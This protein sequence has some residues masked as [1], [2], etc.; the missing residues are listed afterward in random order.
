MIVTSVAKPLS[1][2]DQYS[3]GHLDVDLAE[4]VVLIAIS[5]ISVVKIRGFCLFFTPFKP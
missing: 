5:V 2:Q 1:F 3:T 4:K